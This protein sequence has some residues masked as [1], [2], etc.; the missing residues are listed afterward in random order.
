M[1]PAS[2]QKQLASETDNPA[3][4]YHSVVEQPRH[5]I[6][7]S[8]LHS[9]GD[10]NPF[11]QILQRTTRHENEKLMMSPPRQSIDDSMQQLQPDYVFDENR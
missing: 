3:A 2:I 7:S 5:S 1:S 4:V 6:L 9:G 11:T 8:D 10:F